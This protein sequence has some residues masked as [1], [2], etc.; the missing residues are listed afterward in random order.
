MFRKSTDD[1]SNPSL[2]RMSE[3]V[4]C[5]HKETT[6]ENAPL[7]EPR[8]VD[9]GTSEDRQCRSRNIHGDND[10]DDLQEE[11]NPCHEEDGGD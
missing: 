11:G 7:E 2:N 8:S 6:S 5:P 10:N 9:E 4:S 3:H 1:D